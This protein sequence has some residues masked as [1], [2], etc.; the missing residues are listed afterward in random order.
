MTVK[1]VK[2]TL[3]LLGDNHLESKKEYEKKLVDCI[4]KIRTEIDKKLQ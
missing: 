1:G 3:K 4:S 2:E